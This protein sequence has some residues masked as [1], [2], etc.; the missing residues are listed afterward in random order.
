MKTRLLFVVTIFMILSGCGNRTG[1]DGGSGKNTGKCD[2]LP[3]DITTYSYEEKIIHVDMTYF[4][5][6]KIDDLTHFFDSIASR[7]PIQLWMKDED[8]TND[9][10]KKCIARIDSYRKGINPW[11]PDNLVRDCMRSISFN[12]A[13]INNHD[14]EYTDLVYGEWFMMCAAY[15]SPDITCLVDTQTPDHR[16]G[17]YNYGRPYNDMPWWAYLFLEREKGYEVVCLGDFVA[18]RSIFQLEDELHRKY[19]LCS[20]NHTSFEFNQ[21]LY[22]AKDNGSIIRVTECHT[23]PRPDETETLHYFFDPNRLIWKY[24]RKDNANG[25]LVAISEEPALT[26][27]L[28][29]EDSRFE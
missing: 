22:W 17:F 6:D 16:A 12:A 15:Y 7:H 18:V 10:T 3:A 8:D 21:W 4:D 26:L 14:P 19:Y 5:F 28:D 20:N 24:A 2:V 27:M 23:A 13:I 29:G 9:R 25:R 11:F 1:N